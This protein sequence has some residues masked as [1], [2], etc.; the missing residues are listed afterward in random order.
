MLPRVTHPTDRPNF[1]VLTT[2]TGLRVWFSYETPIAFQPEGRAYPIVREND[3]SK[4]TGR[5]LN[6]VDPNK[7]NRLPSDAFEEALAVH[8][9]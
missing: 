2:E 7:A 1:Y 3:W 8:T 9:A 6:Y 5:H 4:T